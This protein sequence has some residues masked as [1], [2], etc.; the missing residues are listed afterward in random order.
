MFLLVHSGA[1]CYFCSGFI[2]SLNSHDIMH[3]FLQYKYGGI[4]LP[5]PFPSVFDDRWSEHHVKMP[6]SSYNVIP[7]NKVSDGLVVHFLHLSMCDLCDG[8]RHRI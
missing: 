8:H 7:G 2:M 5:K 1:L 4:A 6:C 3:M